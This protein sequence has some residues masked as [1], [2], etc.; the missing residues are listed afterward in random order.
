AGQARTQIAAECLQREQ[1]QVG[2][3]AGVAGDRDGGFSDGLVVDLIIPRSELGQDLRSVHGPAPPSGNNYWTVRTPDDVRE[4]P[5][6]MRVAGFSGSHQP[7]GV[8]ASVAAA[9][10]PLRLRGNGSEGQRKSRAREQSD[11]F[12]AP[13]YSSPPAAGAGRGESRWRPPGSAEQPYPLVGGPT[14]QPV[15]AARSRGSPPS[16][17]SPGD[18][19][20][21][22]LTSEEMPPRRR[23]SSHPAAP[24]PPQRTRSTQEVQGPETT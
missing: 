11:T 12:T 22:G 14:G 2:R 19:C 24:S 17:L 1:P 4:C 6:L 7:D 15:P 9:A 3:A 21:H 8:R 16:P 23:T 18:T 5:P 20:L 10:G 13:P